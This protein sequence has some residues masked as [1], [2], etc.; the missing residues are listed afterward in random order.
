MRVYKLTD[1][2]MQTCNKFQWTLGEKAT[3][4]GEGNLCGPGWLH[5]YP[6]PMLALLMNP[7]AEHHQ[8]QSNNMRMFEAE[9]SGDTR[10][11]YGYRGGSTELTLIR[12]IVGFAKP[13]NEQCVKFGILCAKEA[14]HGGVSDGDLHN[15]AD[16]WIAG[17]RDLEE[18]E[19]AML[20]AGYDE[21]NRTMQM[22]ARAAFREARVPEGG[23]PE[24]PF[25]HAWAA[26]YAYRV[27][28][29]NLI[30]IGLAATL[31]NDH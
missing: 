2:N 4:S 5:W 28:P 15:W 6:D 9:A 30:A 3:T 22:A 26:H 19:V 11:E 27:H 12:E 1:K 24:T 21:K 7:M 13:T 23:K 14:C 17:D 16:K 20:L 10:I 8:V 29:I 25:E 18:I 31:V